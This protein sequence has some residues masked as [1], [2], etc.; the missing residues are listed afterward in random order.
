M[1]LANH[2]EIDEAE[3]LDRLLT[4]V[5]DYMTE[6]TDVLHVSDMVEARLCFRAMKEYH[7]S[8]MADYL[9]ELS[10]ISNKLKHY[11]ALFPI[12]S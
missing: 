11:D 3:D 9:H 4:K 6:K 10:E 12:N 7:K 2:Q 5:D 8:T 1:S